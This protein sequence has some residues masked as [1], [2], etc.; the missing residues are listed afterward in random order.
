ME[1]RDF[2]RLNQPIRLLAQKPQVFIF[3]SVNKGFALLYFLIKRVLI[4][5]LFNP[6]A[7]EDFPPCYKTYGYVIKFPLRILEGR[8][9]ELPRLH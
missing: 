9:I 7:N 4:P 8:L 2:R 3:E 6:L 5:C 1:T